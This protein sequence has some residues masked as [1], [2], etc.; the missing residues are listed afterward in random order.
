MDER[1]KWKKVNKGKRKNYRR[2][3]NELKSPTDIGIFR[4]CEEIIEFQR[5]GNYYLMY[6]KT[7]VGNKSWNSKYRHLRLL[8]EYNS[9][10]DIGTENFGG[11]YYRDL[12]SS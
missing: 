8:R 9:K 5:T 12:R 4:T 10:S 7:M 1:R 3:R 6:L 11:F 2:L